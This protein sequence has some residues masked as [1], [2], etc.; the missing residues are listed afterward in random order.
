MSQNQFCSCFDKNIL[1][2]LFLVHKEGKNSVV[3]GLYHVSLKCHNA[4][5]LI[6]LPHAH[7]K[8]GEGGKVKLGWSAED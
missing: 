2:F 3:N 5:T 4:G 7:C 1:S 8:N 6:S